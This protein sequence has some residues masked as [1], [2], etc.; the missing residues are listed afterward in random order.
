MTVSLFDAPAVPPQ[1]Y[2]VTDLVGELRAELEQ[3][4]ADIWVRGEV[5]GVVRAASGHRYFSLKEGNCVLRCALFFRGRR[6]ALTPEDGME[7]IARGRVSVY[8]PRGDMQFIVSW[9]EDAGE[10]ALRRAFEQLKQKLAGEG[11][12]D[13]E[14]KQPLPSQPRSIGIITSRSGAAL[15]DIRVTLARRYPLARL[16][17]YHTAVQGA[18]A[19]AGIVKMLS[20]ANARRDA[21]VL[22]LARGGGSLSDLHAFNDEGVARA[23][24]ASALP[25]VSAV[26]HEIDYTIAD[27]VADLRAPT[28]TA[29]AE[30]VTPDM[31]ELRQRIRGIGQQ[32]QR[33]TQRGLE[34]LAQR[35]DYARAR[36]PHPQNR[37]AAAQQR[38]QALQNAHIYALRAAIARVTQTRHHLTQQLRLVSPLQTLERGYA[39]LTDP[40][41]GVVRDPAQTR[42]GQVLT[43]RVARGELRCVVEK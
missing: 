24:A 26:G 29:A 5:S 7:V 42:D 37:I 14:R 25:V 23:M 16:V 38:R 35:L 32:I 39:I 19:V 34:I 17:V 40:Q 15:H 31:E 18:D 10:G 36:L 30:L 12:F 43:A 28:P 22:I 11:L 9:L 27:F 4:Y 41:Q 3:N 6:F 1:V 33:T 2:S 21:E 20:L 13:S 8:E